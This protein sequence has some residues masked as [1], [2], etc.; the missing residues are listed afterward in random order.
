[1]SLDNFQSDNKKSHRHAMKPAEVLHLQDLH[2]FGKCVSLMTKPFPPS[3]WT[4]WIQVAKNGKENKQ[5]VGEKPSRQSV[6][7]DT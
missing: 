2:L 4:K 1:M 6:V 7:L 3:G 5:N